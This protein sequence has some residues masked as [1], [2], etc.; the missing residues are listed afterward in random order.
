MIARSEIKSL[1]L[2]AL[3]SADGTPIREDILTETVQ[4]GFTKAPPLVDIDIARRELER[5]KFIAGNSDDL[6]GESTWTLTIKGQHRA[7]QLA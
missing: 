1:I 5:E 6:G 3:L 7:K 2:R 4:K